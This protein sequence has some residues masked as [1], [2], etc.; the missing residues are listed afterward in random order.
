MAKWGEGDPRW[1][2]EERADATNVNNW[3]W[4]ERDASN[5]SMD[6][7]KTLFLAVQVQNEEGTS[8]SGVQYKG[9]V[10]IPNLSDENSVDEV[11]I[12]VS[13][14]K[15]EPDTNLVALMKEEGVKLLRE[16]MGI[17]ISTLKTEFTQGMILP[18]LNGESVDPTG[19][20][21]L[22]TEERTLSQ[23]KAAPSKTQARP[24]GVKIPTC[25]ITLRDTFL[26]SPE[27]LYR[28][29]TTQELV[30]AFTHAPAVLEADKG[31]KFHL[32]DGNVTGEFT[33]LVP[34]KH[35]VM[36][37]RFKSWPEGHFAT[38]T[39]TFNDKN[40]ETEVCMEGRGIPAPEE[41][42]TRQGWQR[43]YFEGIKQTFGYGARLF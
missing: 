5:W 26:T 28:V 11:E 32:V 41:E 33:D 29:F 24:V 23:A 9:H 4:T 10:E 36:K 21:A 1:I 6:K 42:R 40:G 12:S 25:K 30:Q 18:T 20:P 37:W 17:Y 16:A 38:I 19:Q 31:G 34:E 15:D 14:A 2:V 13:L 27:E 43:Y 39:L 3:H 8:K 35:I 22:K 7:L